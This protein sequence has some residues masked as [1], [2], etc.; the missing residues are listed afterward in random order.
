[1]TSV[2]R[3]VAEASKWPLFNELRWEVLK[4]YCSQ[5]RPFDS[6]VDLRIAYAT[7]A[8]RYSKFNWKGQTKCG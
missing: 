4:E 5:R 1:M 3:A 8:G 2:E 6:L 7:V